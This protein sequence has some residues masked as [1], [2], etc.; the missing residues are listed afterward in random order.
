VLGLWGLVSLARLT[1]LVEP[2]DPRPGGAAL[3]PL[4]DFARATIPPTVGYLFV[5]PG[6]FGTD[7]GTAPRL[8]YELA[9]RPY[10]DVRATVDEATVRSLLAA[11]GL[12][13]VV[14]PDASR[15]PADAWLR[16]P[17]AWFRRLELDPQRYL[18][19]VVS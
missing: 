5:L 8:R 11:Q 18:L 7:D 16:Q 12:R 15:Y 17:R 19:E 10:D 14:V 2:P 9:P 13:Y 3:D 1:R 6:A 4:L